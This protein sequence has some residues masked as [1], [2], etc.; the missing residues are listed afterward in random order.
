MCVGVLVS[1]VVGTHARAR[2]RVRMRMSMREADGVS[3]PYIDPAFCSG[4]VYGAF[5]RVCWTPA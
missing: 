5:L 2:A 3:V 1:L 4:A